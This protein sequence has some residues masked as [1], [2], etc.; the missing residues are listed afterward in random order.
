M[1]PTELMVVQIEG[2]YKLYNTLCGKMQSYLN[3][4]AGSIYTP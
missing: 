1:T 3:A 4:V 2:S